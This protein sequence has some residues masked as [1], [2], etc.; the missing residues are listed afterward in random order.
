MY[1]VPVKTFVFIMVGTESIGNCCFLKIVKNDRFG[2]RLW[3]NSH[4]C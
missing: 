3:R 2:R 4:C 1:K